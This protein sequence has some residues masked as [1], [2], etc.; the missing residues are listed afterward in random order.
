MNFKKGIFVLT[1][2]LLM[3]A[4][5]VSAF[6]YYG[7]QETRDNAV[8][9]DEQRIKRVRLNQN[10]SEFAQE[11]MEARQQLNDGTCN[12]SMQQLHARANGRLNKNV[13]D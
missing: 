7:N 6:A 2:I 8:C 9:T 1:A 3:S 13:S 12:G 10:D 11:R 5:T 4:T